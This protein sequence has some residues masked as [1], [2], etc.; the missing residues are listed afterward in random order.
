MGILL[1]AC[2]IPISVE[3][4]V[5]EPQV[6]VDGLITNEPGPYEVKLTYSS[7]YTSGSDGNNIALSGALVTIS[8]DT[9]AK[10][11]LH[12]T[13]QGI[14]L[15]RE[16]FRGSVGRIYTLHITTAEG[17]MIESDPEEMLP[18]PEVDSIYYIFQQI[19]SEKE[20]GHEVFVVVDDPVEDKNFYRWKWDGYYRFYMVSDFE[21]IACFKHE[22]DI[23]K[24]SVVSDRDFNGNKIYFPVSFV[25]HFVND[26]YL[27]HIHQ[28]SLTES[29]YKFWNSLYEQSAS[30]GSIF[31]SQ[32][33]RIKGNLFYIDDTQ[34]PVL[35]YFGVSAHSL[36]YQ[37]MDFN[38]GIAPQYPRSYAF[39]PCDQHLNAFD[40][41]LNDPRWP[42]GWGGW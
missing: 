27:I 1:F 24:I 42:I 18:I 5:I 29:A 32:P 33:A 31:D 3:Y 7:A 37:Y 41:D 12:E 15:T 13:K 20:Q 40:Y 23:N 22:F 34:E 30:V 11:V 25:P 28:Y 39:K 9:G 10:E 6:V 16:G 38:A 35:G 36:G 8:D 26:F 21:T 14:Y 19:S 2:E 4:E 17:K